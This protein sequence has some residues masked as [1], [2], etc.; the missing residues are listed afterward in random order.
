MGTAI[1]TVVAPKR[2]SKHLYGI[3]T[4]PVGALVFE[5]IGVVTGCVVVNP[6]PSPS[7]NPSPTQLGLVALFKRARGRPWLSESPGF[8]AHQLIALVFM[9]ICTLYGGAAPC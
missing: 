5:D 2:T 3:D 1:A 6:N 8:V 7:P 9:S 4:S